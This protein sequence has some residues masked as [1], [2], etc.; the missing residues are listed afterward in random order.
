[1]MLQ[2]DRLIL[3]AAR[4]EDLQDM[5]AIYSDPRAMRYWSTAP[6][7]AP[8]RTQIKLDRMIASAASKLVY[9]VIE[10]DGRVI[11]TAGMH[12]DDEVGFILH[13]DYWRKGIVTEAMGAIVPYL[14]AVTDAAQLTA[15]A[16]PNNTAS[17]NCLKKLGFQETHRAENTFCINGIWSHSVYLALP[18]PA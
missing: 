18:R 5:F 14:F 12:Q 3:R 1:M 11:G 16:D 9:F 6:H 2:T 10:M 7:D 13:P 17:V 8:T 15:D 4:Q